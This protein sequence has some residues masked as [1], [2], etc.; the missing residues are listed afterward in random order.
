MLRPTRSKSM[1]VV[2]I[3]ILT[4]GALEDFPNYPDSAYNIPLQPVG[5]SQKACWPLSRRMN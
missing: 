4:M 2:T 5:Q 3:F 1:F